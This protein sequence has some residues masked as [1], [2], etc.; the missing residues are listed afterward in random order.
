MSSSPTS[1][2]SASSATAGQTESVAPNNHTLNPWPSPIPPSSTGS[3]IEQN[4]PSFADI[5]F[6]DYML[7]KSSDKVQRLDQLERLEKKD[8]PAMRKRLLIT[9]I[10]RKAWFLR[11]TIDAAA[12]AAFI[13]DDT[14]NQGIQAQLMQ[15]QEQQIQQQHNVA[16]VQQAVMQYQQIQLQQQQQQ[17]NNQQQ[18]ELG[19]GASAS[20]AAAMDYSWATFD[21]F[22]FSFLEDQNTD[23]AAAAA[24]SGSSVSTS[25]SF[26]VPTTLTTAGAVA[27]TGTTSGSIQTSD[28]Q[29]G[30][31]ALGPSFDSIDPY[32]TFPGVLSSMGINDSLTMDMDLVAAVTDA[33]QALGIPASMSGLDDVLSEAN[34]TATTAM[35][36]SRSTTGGGVFDPLTPDLDF[37][38]NLAAELASL[39]GTTIN[40]SGTNITIT[41]SNN[42]TYCFGSSPPIQ[43]TSPS[44]TL[45]SSSSIPITACTLPTPVIME[46][47]LS[48]LENMSAPVGINTTTTTTTTA[49]PTSSLMS[50]DK[51]LDINTY[52]NIINGTTTNISTASSTASVPTTTTPVLANVAAKLAVQTGSPPKPANARV[53]PSLS[54]R[55]PPTSPS[56]LMN[57]LMASAS[58]PTQQQ[59]NT[60]SASPS[61]IV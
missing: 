58:S 10:A 17:L 51:V 40:A 53:G 36:L 23:L 47:T 30:L 8:L 5:N 9:Q 27:A 16:A 42:T 11:M 3:F 21:E 35:N 55:S 20:P 33:A 22:D 59:P 25:T 37:N 24:A 15:Q 28:A 1:S 34:L 49:S 54:P 2:S 48:T 41:T 12:A 32:L 29:T 44:T 52:N 45:A 13:Q 26:A 18:T 50:F 31:G 57:A 60:S 56:M 39:N 19:V 7:T 14:Q 6:Y 4:V 46:S 38:F 43:I 61:T